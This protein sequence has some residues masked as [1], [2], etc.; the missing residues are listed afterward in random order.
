M[1]PTP[2]SSRKTRVTKFALRSCMT[3]RLT[4][5]MTTSPGTTSV[6][7]LAFARIFSIMFID[8]VAVKDSL[9][10]LHRLF[11]VLGHD[12]ARAALVWIGAIERFHQRGRCGQDHP[13]GS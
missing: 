8:R 12:V 10:V 2:I 3:I 6:L 9:P 5:A 4:F 11:T 1:D 7:P 13:V